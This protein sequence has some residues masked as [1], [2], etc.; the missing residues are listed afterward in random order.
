MDPPSAPCIY[1]QRGLFSS[2]SVKLVGGLLITIHYAVTEDTEAALY[3]SYDIKT[4]VYAL[5]ASS[6]AEVW[7]RP[8]QGL[9]QAVSDLVLV[10]A[11]ETTQLLLTDID[12]GLQ[13]RACAHMC[14]AAVQAA[15]R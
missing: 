2:N 11:G 13:V 8:L 5:N 12:G 3:E 14:S 1:V 9:V 10:P 15:W 6:G 7:S 4:V